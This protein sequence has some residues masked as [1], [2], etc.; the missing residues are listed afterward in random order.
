MMIETIDAEETGI[1][2][3]QAQAQPNDTTL[4]VTCSIGA[5]H[6]GLPI[7]FVR[8]VVRLPALIHLAGAPPFVCGLL[9]LRGDYIPVMDGRILVEES[10]S[11]DTS[12]QIIV[13]GRVQPEFG[14]LVDRVIDVHTTRHSQWKPINQQAAAAFLQNVINT[15]DNTVLILDMA[16]LLAFVPD[17]AA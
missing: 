7:E 8:E 10:A 5:Q 6:Y 1:T 2:I 4:I 17:V 15:N 11:Y 3:Q 16:T 9:N 14:L 12:K 13:A